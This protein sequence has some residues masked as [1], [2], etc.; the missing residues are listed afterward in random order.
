[1][2]EVHV[3]VAGLD[4]VNLEAF[5]LCAACED[6]YVRGGRYCKTCQRIDLEL[7]AKRISRS[8]AE[9]HLLLAG[10]ERIETGV[11]ADNGDMRTRDWM[12]VLGLLLASVLMCFW[13][14]SFA[15][16]VVDQT[17]STPPA[18]ERAR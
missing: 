12:L 16:Q 3:S 4:G 6:V 14:G 1:M 15:D 11:R 2:N 13:F 8:P 5:Q 7:E 17:L 18:M 9:M 10:L